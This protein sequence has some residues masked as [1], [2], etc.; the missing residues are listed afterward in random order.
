MRQ[1]GTWLPMGFVAGLVPLGIL[2]VTVPPLL[3]LAGVYALFGLPLMLH[4]SRRRRR[5]QFIAKVRATGALPGPEPEE[6]H[7]R[8]AR[9]FAAYEHKRHEARLDAFE[10]ARD[11]ERSRDETSAAPAPASEPQPE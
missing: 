10:A 9:A 3:A 1:G 2:G 8:R 4:A 6:E 11:V 5:H 7:E